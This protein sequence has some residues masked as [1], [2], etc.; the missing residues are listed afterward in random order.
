MAVLRIRIR[1]CFCRIRIH[2]ICNGSRS[3][4]EP[5]LLPP[6][7]PSSFTLNLSPLLPLPTP[8]PS[9]LTPPPLSIIIHL[10]PITP[11]PSPLLL[12]TSYVFPH[13]SSV[14]PHYRY[15][16]LTIQRQPGRL[17]L[18]LNN[19]RLETNKKPG[20]KGFSEERGR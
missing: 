18:K 1:I 9:H 19:Y 10:S 3:R 17:Q 6:S 12:H 13:T 8:P 7:L 2:N 4:N 20:D 14:F 16:S 5:S 11:P 15:S